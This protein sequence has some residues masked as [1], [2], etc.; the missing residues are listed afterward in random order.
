[1]LCNDLK[2][3]QNGKFVFRIPNE[4]KTLQRFECKKKGNKKQNRSDDMNFIHTNIDD[5]FFVEGAF[6]LINSGFHSPFTDSVMEGVSSI[7]TKNLL[8]QL[9]NQL[10]G[11]IS[12]LKLRYFPVY[13]FFGTG[14]VLICSY[15]QF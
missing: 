1:M 9:L 15:F 2:N 8:N 10:L 7:T 4:F 12:I 6:Y 3:K 13:S 11:G 14:W 5:F